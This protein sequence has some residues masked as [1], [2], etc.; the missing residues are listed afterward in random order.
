[1]ANLQGGILFRFPGRLLDAL[2]NQRPLCHLAPPLCGSHQFGPCTT[3]S[4]EAEGVEPS[5]RV[6]RSSLP[7]RTFSPPSS[8]DCQPARGSIVNPRASRLLLACFTASP[9]T[10]EGVGQAVCQYCA[11]HYQNQ[12][13]FSIRS[14]GLCRLLRASSASQKAGGHSRSRPE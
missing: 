3:P 11:P 9:S 4:M 1:M 7:G 13:A 14:Q 2:A 8:T 10:P 6:V 5:S 12:A